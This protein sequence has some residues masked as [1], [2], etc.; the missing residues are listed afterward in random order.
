MASSFDRW[1]K[2]PFF[3]AAEE[4]QESADRME[5]TYRTWTHAKD[6][7]SNRWDSEELRRDLQTSL[8]TAKWQLEEFERAVSTSYGKSSSDEARNRHQ[9]FIAAIQ[10]KVRKVEQSLQESIVSD[11]KALLP[12]VRLNEGER[13]ELA[14]FLSGMPANEGKTPR[15]DKVR[16]S[17]CQQLCDKDSDSISK[18]LLS[19]E[20]NPLE[21]KEESS[22]GHRRIASA[23]AD[24]SSWKIAVSDDVQPYSSSNRS[25][26]PVHKVPSFSGFFNSM[27]S[28]S[29]IKWPKNAFRKLKAADN[30]QGAH[31]ALLPSSELNRGISVCYERSKS[32]LDSYDKCY[33]KQLYGWYGAIQRQLQRSQYLMQYSRPVLILFWMVLSLSLI[34]LV[35]FR[36]V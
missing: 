25:F 36:A 21:T 30:N 9:D 18:N 4:V 19:S 32:Y 17:E 11:G 29:K 34:V 12:W 35:A 27:E 15:K 28:V 2:D 16:D 5:S 26:G 7:A 13:N 3:A 33:D 24:F 14:L 20:W 1:E 6:D 10:E 8:G 22:H 23:S 31:S